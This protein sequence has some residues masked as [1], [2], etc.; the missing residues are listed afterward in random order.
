MSYKFENF[1]HHEQKVLWSE[2]WLKKR[3][4]NFLK[5]YLIFDG[6]RKTRIRK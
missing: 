5:L 4:E 2:Q 6:M 1:L 3:K